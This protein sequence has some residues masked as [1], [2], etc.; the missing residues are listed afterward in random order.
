MYSMNDNSPVSSYTQLSNDLKC[1]TNV[2]YYEFQLFSWN[3]K[4]IQTWLNIKWNSKCMITWCDVMYSDFQLFRII[5]MQ[6]ILKNKAQ[7][8]WINV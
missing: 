2:M 6:N 5:C 7:K 3:T 8:A 1:S 4:Y